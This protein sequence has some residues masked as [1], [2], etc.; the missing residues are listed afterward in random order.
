MIKFKNLMKDFGILEIN[1][2]K[3]IEPK[4][5]S[6]IPVEPKMNETTGLLTGLLEIVRE[7]RHDSL[8]HDSLTHDSLTTQNV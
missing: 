1:L 6:E 5:I 3:L 4:I 8:T 2:K 7:V